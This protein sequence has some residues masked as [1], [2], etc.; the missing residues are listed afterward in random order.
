MEAKEYSMT[1]KFSVT[2]LNEIKI[3]VAYSE[4]REC[5][6]MFTVNPEMARDFVDQHVVDYIEE[7]YDDEDNEH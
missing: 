3:E 2:S 6:L 5:S 4:E 7:M 1:I